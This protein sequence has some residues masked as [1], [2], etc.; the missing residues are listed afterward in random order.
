MSKLQ[1]LLRTLLDPALGAKIRAWARVA[2]TLATLVTLLTI[3]GTSMEIIIGA[4]AAFQGA[5]AIAVARPT[6]PPQ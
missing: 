1:N 5:L 4:F 6:T 3:K 2:V